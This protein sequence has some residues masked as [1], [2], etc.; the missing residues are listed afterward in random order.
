VGDPDPIQGGPDPI[1]GVWS[2]HVGVLD[3]P[4]GLDRIYRGPA[5]SHGGPDSMSML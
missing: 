1:L 4:G 3:Q 5:L 2:V